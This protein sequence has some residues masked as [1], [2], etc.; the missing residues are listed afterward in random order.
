MAQA[1]ER[2]NPGRVRGSNGGA[3]YEESRVRVA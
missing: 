2:V 1:I 3:A